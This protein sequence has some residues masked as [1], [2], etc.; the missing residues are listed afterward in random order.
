MTKQALCRQVLIVEDDFLIAMM[1]EDLVDAHGYTVVATAR[2]Y[3][4]ALEHM[5]TV[6]IAFVDVNLSDGCTGPDIGAVLAEHGVSVIFMTANPEMLNGGVRGTV[7][8]VS[9]PVHDP[10]MEDLLL[11]AEGHCVGIRAERI[12][13]SLRVFH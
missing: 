11:F 2:D 5:D 13:L 7:G 10:D 4:T 12:P 8:V 3:A 1:M 9:K 6:G